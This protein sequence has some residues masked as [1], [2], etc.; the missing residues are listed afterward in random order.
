MTK[1]KNSKI[2]K[3]SSGDF[4]FTNDTGVLNLTVVKNNNLIGVSLDGELL[5]TSPN[6]PG[7]RYLKAFD[8]EL[9]VERELLS[10]TELH[11]LR[12]ELTRTKVVKKKNSSRAKAKS[13]AVDSIAAKILR[14]EF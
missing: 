1:K 11:D 7:F 13:N 5:N 10:T 2:H 6:A 8:P 12:R 14:G 3:L 4:I 9:A